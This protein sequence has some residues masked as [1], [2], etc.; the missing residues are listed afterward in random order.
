MGSFCGKD[1]PISQVE[2]E[3]RDQDAK[4]QKRIEDGNKDERNVQKLLLL[5]AG[6]SGKSTIFKQIKV[7]YKDG[8]HEA[9]LKDYVH[10]IHANVYQAIKA[11]YD[12]CLQL[13]DQVTTGVYILHPDNKVLGQKLSEMG[14]K[15]ISELPI[16]DEALAQEIDHVWKDPA[17]QAT[18]SRASE[19]QIPDCTHYFL[20]NV[21]RLAGPNYMPT[22]D[23]ILYARVKTTGV[24]QIEFSPLGKK[25]VYRLVDVGGQRN[26]RKKWI[27]LFDGVTAVIFCAALSE[28]DQT[29]YEDET[30]NRMME[31]K[32]LFEW[33]LKQPWFEKTSFLLF[34]NKFDIFKKKALDVSLTSCEWF[35]DYTPLSSG[36]PEY[37][38][39]HAYRY[40]KK[41]FEDVYAQNTPQS[42][43]EKV[44][45]IYKT[46]ALDPEL[47]KETFEL[48]DKTLTIRRLKEAD[49]L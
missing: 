30:K 39:E 44:F 40:I 36:R 34:L 49:Y 8:L 21:L 37:D 19:L 32:E 42:S 6:E 15:S 22:K 4:I 11:L 16:L 41:K 7:L 38:V 18:Y 13:G 23:D 14:D 46:T 35:Q 45:K 26:E 1:M 48:V 43:V 9:E 25:E 17:I 28:Y 5:G 47:V 2:P 31:T 12:G 33:I 29:L 3:E 20:E 24:A 10:V 27:H